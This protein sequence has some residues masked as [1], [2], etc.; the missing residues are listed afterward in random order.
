MLFFHHKAAPPKPN[1]GTMLYA[2][3][4]LIFAI[5]TQYIPVVGLVGLGSLLILAGI[6]V[7]MNATRI[8]ADSQKWG[9]KYRKKL[10]WWNRP[11]S[12]FYAVNTYVL[13]PLII[14]MGVFALVLAYELVGIVH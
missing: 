2:G 10:P 5:M 14:V 13:W 12:F 11:T 4:I 9:K 7:E 8:W 3:L 1:Y 6:I